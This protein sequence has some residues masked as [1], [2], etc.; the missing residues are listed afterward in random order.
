MTRGKI[1]KT[2]GRYFT[3]SGKE[4]E[5]SVSQKTWSEWNDWKPVHC[6]ILYGFLSKDGCV[7]CADIHWQHAILHKRFRVPDIFRKNDASV[8]NP[9]SE[10]DTEVSRELSH[11]TFLARSD[12]LAC[13]ETLIEGVAA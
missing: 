6:T 9:V 13:S 3:N 11:Q 4:E 12:V 8:Y 5:Q 7:L 1:P 2:G 10:N